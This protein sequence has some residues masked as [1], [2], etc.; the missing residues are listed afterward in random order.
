MRSQ[1]AAG[2]LSALLVSTMGMP[3]SAGPSG[4]RGRTI[5]IEAD[6][7]SVD[8]TTSTAVAR[9]RV[10]ISDGVRTAT[11]AQATIE[12]RRGRSVLVGGAKVV[13][14]RGTL[15]GNEITVM[16]TTR[17]ITRIVAR[18][19]AT[20]ETS[21]TLVQ[22]ET[23][24]LIPPTE[25]VTAEREVTVFTKPDIIATGTRLTYARTRGEMLLEG[26]VRVQSADG[27]I[28]GRRLDG[29]E[30]MKRV[31]V[32]GDV[33]AVYRDI[34]IRSNAAM[35]FGDEKRATFTGDVRVE[36]PGR[37]LE[38][39]RATVWYSAGRVLAEGPTRMRFDPAP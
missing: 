16:F 36:Q 4:Q 35:V 11:A 6:A 29:D 3:V 9:G 32:T 31:A 15:A 13:D 14:P 27:F 7:V 21:T 26:P 5:V 28:E 30:R 20:L 2:L 39:E 12:Q 8:A 25:T 37:A 19:S 1:L 33:H 34:D 17:A 24:T 38:T 22:A 23:I 18:A 10:R